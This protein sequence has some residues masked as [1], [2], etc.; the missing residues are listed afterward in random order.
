MRKLFLVIT[1]LALTASMTGCSKGT[2]DSAYPVL[3]PVDGPYGITFENMVS[4]F[5]DISA[6]AWLDAQA[7]IKR[8]Q[9]LPSA[10]KTLYTYI[11]PEALKVDP[12]IGEVVNLLK[13]DFSLFAR[14]PSYPKV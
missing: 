6:A 4:K 5:N 14:F 1:S 8:N 11:S 9:N 3:K 13:R 12:R 7:T 10:S 2:G